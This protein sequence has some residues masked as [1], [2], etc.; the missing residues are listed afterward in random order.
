MQLDNEERG[1]S[2]LK[3]G[4]LD[5]RM[6]LDSKLTA[7]EIINHY[8]EK[9]LGKLFRDFGEERHWKIAAKAITQARKKKPIET[10]TE[11]ANIIC[12]AIKVN[13]KKRHPATLIFQALRLCVNRELESIQEGVSKAIK[14]LAPEGRI[15]VLAFHSLEDRIVK[16][17]LRQGSEPIKKIIRDKEVTYLPL[18][19]LLSKKPLVPKFEESKA[20]RRARSAKLRVAEKI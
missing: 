8:S 19:K 16:N 18:L 2:F 20:N 12:S 10:T 6:D 1:F 3:E 17:V 15:G 5:M 9:E 4:E 11:L 13:R 14:H 7:K